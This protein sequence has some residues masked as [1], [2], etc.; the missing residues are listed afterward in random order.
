MK[1]GDLVVFNPKPLPGALTA[2]KYY[3]RTLEQTRGLVGVV[4]SISGENALISFGNNNIVLNHK[5]LEVVN[6][7][8]NV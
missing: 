6:G 8:Q 5:Y 3:Y 2:A 7:K 4:L 1:V